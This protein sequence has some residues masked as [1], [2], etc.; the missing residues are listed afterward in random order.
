VLDWE[1]STLGEPLADFTYLL[2]NWEITGLARIPDLEAHGIPTVPQAVD[3]YCQLTGRS[4]LPDLNWYFA[5]NHY[6]LACI[7]QGILG[8]VRDGTAKRN[9]SR[10]FPVRI[11]DL[12][13]AGWTFAQ[14]A[15]G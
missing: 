6:R 15:Q 11:R 12:S 5:Y 1:L 7:Y 2:M 4:G 3:Y 8:R 14:K 13:A 9:D 10:D